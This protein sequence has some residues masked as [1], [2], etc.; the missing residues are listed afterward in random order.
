MSI[1]AVIIDDEELSI[2]VLQWELQG[3]NE[4]VEIVGTAS[5][6]ILGIEVIKKTRPDLVFLDIEM[7][8][9]NGIELIGSFDQVDF[10]VI[11]TTAYDHYALDAIKK[12]ALDY[13][14][15]PVQKEELEK[16]IQKHLSKSNDQIGEK[17]Q[18]IFQNVIRNEQH[19]KIIIPTAEGLEFVKIAEI[20]RCES[21]SN[22][23]YIFLRNGTKLLV[24]KTLKDVEQMIGSD[25]FRRVHK[26]HLINFN[27]VS[28]YLKSEGGK[29]VM[30]DG[31]EVPISRNKKGE[32]L[33]QL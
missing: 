22:Y 27:F 5:D 8:K 7:P 25:E 11:F 19:Q 33:D 4:P 12:E 26:S 18:S 31:A 16:A 10:N 13:L 28:R 32:F 30:E 29:I 23:T 17:I 20:L 15:K 9:M 24:S 6:P 3:L 1:K 21:S 14:L 2:D